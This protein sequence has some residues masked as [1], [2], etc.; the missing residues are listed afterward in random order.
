VGKWTYQVDDNTLITWHKFSI[1]DA[2]TQFK[3]PICPGC[4]SLTAPPD[5][6]IDF[7]SEFLVPRTGG[8]VTIDGVEVEQREAG[9]P[10]FQQNQNYLLFISLYPNRIALT[11]GGPLGVFRIDENENLTSFANRPDKIQEGIKTKFRGSLPSI[12]RHLKG[13]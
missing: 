8:T 11:A 12:K 1:V 5:I 7:N 4:L 10:D 2:L 13:T 9:F 3:N 6:P